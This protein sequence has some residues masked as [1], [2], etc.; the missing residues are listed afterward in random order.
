MNIRVKA[1]LLTAGSLAAG[2]IIVLAVHQLTQS[3]TTDQVM[4]IFGAGMTGF[5]VYLLYS[6]VLNRLEY[7]QKL[8]EIVESQKK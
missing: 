4:I 7:E 3:L 6:I 2:I 5:L 8:A 1:A